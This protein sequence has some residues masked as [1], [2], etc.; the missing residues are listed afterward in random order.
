LIRNTENVD[1]N[2]KTKTRDISNPDSKFDNYGVLIGKKCL[3][4]H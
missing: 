1:E 4:Y 2:E 3:I